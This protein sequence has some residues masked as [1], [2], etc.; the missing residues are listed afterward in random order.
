MTPTLATAAYGTFLKIGDGAT[1]ESFATIAEVLDI[2]GPDFDSESED[3]TSHDSN[4]WEEKITTI[5]K[6]GMVNFALNFVPA[7][8]THSYSS[9]LLA[10]YVNR[11]LR[12]F[13]LVIPSGPTWSFSAF[14][15]K[16]P[17]SFPVKGKKGATVT[18]D[19]SGQPSLA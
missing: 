4:G 18:L 15:R 9:G 2:N 3:A 13:Q 16:I 5:L 1:P 11:T 12:H 8:A 10:D 6:A 17:M 7:H 14:V 19:I